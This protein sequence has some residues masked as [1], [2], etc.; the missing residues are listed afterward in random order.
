MYKEQ[1]KKLKDFIERIPY[2]NDY[3]NYEIEYP[4]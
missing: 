1:K 2:G 4:I 3:V